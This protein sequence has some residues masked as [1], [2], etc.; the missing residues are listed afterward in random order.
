[1]SLRIKV[2]KENDL[3]SGFIEYQNKCY[4]ILINQLSGNKYI[5]RGCS[6]TQKLLSESSKILAESLYK[7]DCLKTAWRI[8]GNHIK[9]QIDKQETYIL[10]PENIIKD[11]NTIGFSNIIS[12]SNNQ[13]VIMNK[14]EIIKF[15]FNDVIEGSFKNIIK[16]KGY[17]LFSVYTT[18]I[19]LMNAY[20][21]EIQIIKTISKN[22]IADELENDQVFVFDGVSSQELFFNDNQWSY[23]GKSYAR[24]SCLVLEAPKVCQ[25]DDYSCGICF[26]VYL[27]HL[28]PSIRCEICNKSYHRFCIKEWLEAEGNFKYLNFNTQIKGNCLFCSNKDLVV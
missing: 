13:L 10:K 19:D 22:Y 4:N 14:Q 16:V 1:M 8:I 20:S 26:S 27:D 24:T 9:E 5:L 23:K 11:L 25:L 7:A 6:Q 15:L 17:S 28:L 21:Q 2:K 18:I 3:R 12:Y